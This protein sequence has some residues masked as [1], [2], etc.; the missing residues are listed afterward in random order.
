MYI[1]LQDIL[2]I[3]VQKDDKMGVFLVIYFLKTKNPQTVMEIQNKKIKNLPLY[4]FSLYFFILAQVYL[5][6]AGLNFT[7]HIRCLVAN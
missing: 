2:K 7:Y 1:G 3:L 4:L 5:D 6:P